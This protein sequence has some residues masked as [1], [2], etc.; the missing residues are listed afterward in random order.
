MFT[1][2]LQPLVEVDAAVD[3]K[4]P[5]IKLFGGCDSYNRLLW[6]AACVELGQ[7]PNASKDAR[8]NTLGGFHQLAASR[9]II[10]YPDNTDF[11]F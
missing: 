9:P 4:W 7:R 6:G 5:V 1:S 8:K 2:T 3:H 10:S 11:M